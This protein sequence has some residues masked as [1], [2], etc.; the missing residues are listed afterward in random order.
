MLKSHPRHLT[1]VKNYEVRRQVKANI[2]V[3]PS[4]T[5][6]L[7]VMDRNEAWSN[8][9]GDVSSVLAPPLLTTAI[10]PTRGHFEAS[11]RNSNAEFRSGALIQNS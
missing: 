3:T 5:R 10:T 9:E 6:G 11:F 7:L 1:M 4:A 2:N 8:D